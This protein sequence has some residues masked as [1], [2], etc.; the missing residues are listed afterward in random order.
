MTDFAQKHKPLPVANPNALFAR[1]N[2]VW[3]HLYRDIKP[4]I[5][6]ALLVPCVHSAALL[7]I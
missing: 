2:F 7:S 6:H 4:A 3:N 1:Q 5:K